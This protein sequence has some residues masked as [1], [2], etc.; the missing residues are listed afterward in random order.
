MIIIKDKSYS[1]E[2]LKK[3][4][5]LNLWNNSLEDWEIS[6][7][8]FLSFWFDTSIDEIEIK[9]SGSTGKPKTISHKKEYMYASALATC[10]YF[11]LDKT[12]MALLCLPLSSIGGVMMLVRS[13]VSG[14][15]LIIGK[16]KSNPLKYLNQNIDFIAMVPMQVQKSFD[17]S[18]SKWSFI[19]TVI[20][21]GGKVS[22]SLKN[23]IIE[24]KINAYSTFG[25]TETISHIALNK[26]GKNN[27]YTGLENCYF[28]TNSDN[29][30]IISAVHLG[31]ENIHTN[32]VIDLLD[33]KSFIWLGRKDNAI[34]TGGIKIL[35]EIVEQKIAHLFTER[36]FIGSI[37]DKILNNKIV[38]LIEKE[39]SIKIEDLKEY[40]NKF[41]CPKEIY[42]LD[43]FIETKSGKLDRHSTIRLI[44][45]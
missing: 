9:T 30:L 18:L 16:P 32:D 25:M 5:A 37:N 11:R 24:N 40:L 14:M 34:E 13:L 38:L 6:F 28:S 2:S 29:C 8:M 21:G 15:N 45:N 44:K 4:C 19:K 27:I 7:W 17:E 35:P 36:F 22:N 26:I 31:V 41:E 20:I 23:T 1:I 3:T 42:S 33:N 39:S 12:K 10:K 43:K